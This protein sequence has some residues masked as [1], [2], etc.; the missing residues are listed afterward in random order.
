[1]SY[2]SGVV[3]PTVLGAGADRCAARRLRF[4]LSLSEG[5]VRMESGNSSSLGH[6]PSTERWEFDSEVT[7]VFDDM[8]ERSIPQ[9]QT[10]RSSVAEI[11]ARRAKEFSPESRRILDLGCSR[12]AAIAS[13][14]NLAPGAEFVGLE[15]SPPMVA[16]SRDRF[17][18]NPHITIIEHDLRTPGL[19]YGA[20]AAAMAILTVQFV[21]IEHRQRI[22]SDVYDALLPGGIFV[23]VEKILGCDSQTDRLFVDIYLDSKGAAGYSRD[24]IDRKRAA[25]EG[26]LVPVTASWN[27]QLLRGA[28][29]GSV[30]CFWRWMNFAGWVAT[31]R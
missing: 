17:A 27:E 15:V 26:V 22:I 16:A 31:K 8:L 7:R 3:A 6:R 30:D 5:D 11:V 23:M 29:F 25:L 4:S 13:V 20:F 28:G 9:H 10:M 21:P 12:G 14:A 1:M 24:E 18:A 2:I 19:Q